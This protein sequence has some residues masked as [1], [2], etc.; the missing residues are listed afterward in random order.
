[1]KGLFALSLLP[2]LA[3]SSP[4]FTQTDEDAAPILSSSQTEEVS[5]SYMVVF[6][7]DITQN[8]AL[9][10]HSWVQN[11]HAQVET[12]KTKKRDLSHLTSAAHEGLKHTY[13][14]PGGLLGYS[15]HFD[16]GVIESVRRHPQVCAS[17]FRA[18]ASILA[19]RIE[20]R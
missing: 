15:G 6:K 7:K 5:D 14:I 19:K 8:A 11:L 16:E 18:S 17:K 13:N 3:S 10:H 20:C 12:S 4:L 1:M 2:L 9:E